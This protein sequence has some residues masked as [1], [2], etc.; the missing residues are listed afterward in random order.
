MATAPLTPTAADLAAEAATALVVVQ[1]RPTT[2]GESTRKPGQALEDWLTNV[3]Y[4]RLY[5]DCPRQLPATG[6][7]ACRAAWVRLRSLVGVAIAQQPV[8]PPAPGAW[9]WP[10]AQTPM[11]WTAGGKFGAKRPW[12]GPQT[13]YHVGIDLRA[14]LGTAVRAPEAGIILSGTHGWESTV[15]AVVMRTDSGRTVLIGG[16]A[17]GTGAAKNTLVKAG[18]TI[19]K[20]GA[21]PKGDTMAHVTVWDRPLTLG[22]VVARQV[23]RLG[24][25]K[26]ESLI[27]PANLLRSGMGQ[28]VPQAALGDDDNGEE[29]EG[30]LQV[31]LGELLGLFLGVA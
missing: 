23:W 8:A 13:R 30:V 14:G 27:D 7:A 20:I 16:I 6:E 5:S 31:P 3:A 25:P 18:D 29:Q 9:V 4:W 28:N 2:H 10:V 19:G 17:A 26:P 12:K 24:Q 22:Q 15:K 11:Y 21:Y 1:E